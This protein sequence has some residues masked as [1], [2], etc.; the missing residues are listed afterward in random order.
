MN[1]PKPIKRS[2]SPMA[3]DGRPIKPTK[4]LPISQSLQPRPTDAQGNFMPRVQ[5]NEEAAPEPKKGPQFADGKRR[6]PLGQR[7]SKLRVAQR[8]GFVRRWINDVPGRLEAALAGGYAHVLDPRKDN[9]PVDMYVGTAEKGGGQM[10]YLM[11]IPQE[12]ADEDFAIKQES[13]DAVD[14]A[15]YGGTFDEEEGDNRY[16]PKSAPIKFGTIRGQGRG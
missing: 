12:F 14:K 11:E 1:S 6:V 5:L 15:I 10:A 13:L 2:T 9:K 7:T 3:D 8:P 4:A 16:K